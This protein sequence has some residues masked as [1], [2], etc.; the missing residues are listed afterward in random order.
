MRARSTGEVKAL[1]FL[2]LFFLVNSVAMA[3][4]ACQCKT[5]VTEFLFVNEHDAIQRYTINKGG[6]AATWLS[7]EH[8]FTLAP[9]DGKIIVALGTIPCSAAPGDYDLELKAVSEDGVLTQTKVFS[10]STCH[11]FNVEIAQDEYDVCIDSELII[12]II[13]TN[14]GEYEEAVSISSSAGSLVDGTVVILSKDENATITL[15]FTPDELITTGITVKAVSDNY[16]VSKALT[17]NG[18]ECSFF[19]AELSTDYVGLCENEDKSIDLILTNLNDSDVKAYLLIDSLFIDAPGEVDLSANETK[20]VSLQIHST[21]DAQVLTPVLRVY[22]NGSERK[23]LSLTLNFRS[24]YQPIIIASQKTDNVCACENTSYDFSIYN[25]GIKEMTYALSAGRGVISDENGSSISEIRLSPDGSAKLS[26]DSLIECDESGSIPITIKAVGISVCN[27]SSEDY[28]NLDVKSWSEC[29]AVSVESIDAVF[30]N[31]SGQIV[32]QVSISNIGRR[33]SSYNIEVSGSAMPYLLGIN[34]GFVTLNPGESETV[35]LTLKPYNF[36]DASIIITALSL[37]N[38]AKD[39]KV[40]SLIN[41][42]Y[43]FKFDFYYL[44]IPA[45]VAVLMI[46]VFLRVGRKEK[47]RDSTT[48]GKPKIKKAEIK[49]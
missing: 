4:N 37:D 45:S 20:S 33:P 49:K 25:P 48:K 27:K 31:E 34:T 39:T 5:V 2:S 21:C 1:I 13:I 24:C 19:N 35:E 44:L 12:P 30:F 46:I 8:T 9:G 3:V 10:V 29:E 36:S 17:I 43:V 7:T 41:T 18:I 11:S 14:T 42:E 16:E 23:S 32:I 47:A 15:A 6:T 26:I 40:I 22:V 28:V 38:L